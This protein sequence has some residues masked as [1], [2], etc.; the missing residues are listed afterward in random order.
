MGKVRA[1]IQR[2]G[3]AVLR[4]MGAPSL[5]ERFQLELWR[6]EYPGVSVPP[7]VIWIRGD[8]VIIVGVTAAKEIV[9]IRQYKK[10]VMAE[11]LVL[12]W[13]GVEEGET[14]R[15]AAAREFREETGYAFDD[16]QVIVH[17]PFFDLPNKSTGRHWVVVARD[18]WLAGDPTPDD[19]EMISAI[20]QIPMGS[21]TLEELTVLM[22]IG[23]LKFLGWR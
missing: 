13:G 15:E 6:F 8:S 16:S 2:V 5:S 12:P 17:G 20:E 21:P 9:F 1:N 23:A 14:P 19:G 11:L 18:V 4:I 22:H 10:A 3:R 7:D